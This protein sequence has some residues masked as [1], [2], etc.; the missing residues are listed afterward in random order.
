M[1]PTSSTPA[2]ERPEETTPVPVEEPQPE[3]VPDDAVG[4]A[5]AADAPLPAPEAEA[6]TPPAPEL[7]APSPLD[8]GDAEPVAADAPDLSAVDGRAPVEHA[9]ATNLD[10]PSLELPNPA[11]PA[12]PR[13][14]V[15]TPPAPGTPTTPYG[16]G[17]SGADY[18]ENLARQSYGAPAPTPPAAAPYADTP[19]AAASGAASGYAEPPFAQAAQPPAAE[20][21]GQLVPASQLSASDENLWATAAHWS[22]LVASVI[23]LPFLGPLLVLLIQGPK[24]ARVRAQAVESLNFD[25]TMTIAMLLSVMLVFL[26]I[27][28]VTTPILGI[29]WL[30]FKIVATVQTASGQDYRYPL[31]IRMVK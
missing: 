26:L 16:V 22:T 3:P 15:P 13:P 10:L 7:P 31:N 24:S 5:P 23:G 17:A 11:P 1:E 2:D 6:A 18:T 8:L 14:P 28:V 21:Y 29:L 20:Q 4:D 9:P 19:Y 12:A 25:L 30:V 27:G